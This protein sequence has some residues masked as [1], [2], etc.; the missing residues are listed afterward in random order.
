VIQF[1]IRADL[2]EAAFRGDELRKLGAPALAV[3]QK[4]NLLRRGD[5]LRMVECDACGSPHIEEVD[6]IT[7]SP[8]GIP[9]AYI[10]CEE[11]GRRV[12]VALDRLQVWTIESSGLVVSLLWPSESR[13][14]RFRWPKI[15]SGC[16]GQADSWTEPAMFSW[17]VESAGRMAKVCL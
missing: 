5:D 10:P 15:A 8:D 12:S 4:E 2:E 11:T 13:V 17:F 1:W 3:L 14:A 7:D 6:I 9:R 16:W